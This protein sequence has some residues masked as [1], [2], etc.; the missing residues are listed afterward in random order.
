MSLLQDFGVS[1]RVVAMSFDTTASNTG[2][3]QGAC[4]RLESHL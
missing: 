4:A 1:D 2:S 3:R